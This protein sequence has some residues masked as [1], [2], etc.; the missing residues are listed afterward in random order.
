MRNQV[1]TV[2]KRRPPR[3]HSCSRSRSPLRQLAAA[4]P[5]QVMKPNSAAKMMRAVQFTSCTAITPELRVRGSARELHSIL[6]REIDDRRQNGADNHPSKLVP[7][8][9]RETG[10][11]GLHR[12]IEGRPKNGDELDHEEQVPPAPS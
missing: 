7:V 9:E 4:K 8:E 12:V 11:G 10:E 6:G 5:N 3:P 2:P 1:I